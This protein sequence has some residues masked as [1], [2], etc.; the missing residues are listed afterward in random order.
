MRQIL[1]IALMLLPLLRSAAT[2]YTVDDVP[3][4]HRTD[5]TDFVADPGNVLS[6][7][8][9]GELNRIMQGMRKGLT[10]EPMVVVIDSI[11]SDTDIDTFATELFERWGMG[12]ADRDNGLL[13]LVSTGA[14]KVTIRT[15]YGLEGA[16][17]DIT[18]GRIIRE[19]ML[20]AFSE[21]NYGPGLTGAMAQIFQVLTDPAVAEEMRSEQPDADETGPGE[22]ID[23]FHV[24]LLCSGFMAFILLMVLI[25]DLLVMQ[26]RSDDDKYR[27]LVKS[28]D[29]WI[30]LS[31]LGLGIPCV[32]SIPYLLLLHRWRN[33]TRICPACGHPMQKIDEV[34]DND[35]L[36]PS[37]DMEEQLGSVDYDVWHCEQC[38]ETD[39]IPFVS[40]KSDYVEC[41]NCHARTARLVAD[42][43]V[44]QPTHT[45]PGLRV[46]EYECLNCHH[47]QQR[48]QRIDSTGETKAKL[49]MGLGAVAGGAARAGGRFGGGGFSGGSFGGGFG[50]GSTGGGGATGSW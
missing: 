34:H 8:D 36:T 23:G 6:P 17:P 13:V 32:A 4:V 42:R 31:F 30:I 41:D 29:M 38:G 49:V 47:R 46:K 14:R 45:E 19:Y 35:Y 48:R 12:K 26:G 33:R 25:I 22:E 27:H 9:R 24:Y 7:N 5:R 18:C 43:E 20:P 3:D 28:K 37:Q 15:G 16:L 1:L 21:G 44:I 10:V 11:A 40:N 39:I 50:G 2:V